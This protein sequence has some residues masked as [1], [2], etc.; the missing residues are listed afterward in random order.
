MERTENFSNQYPAKIR[1]AFVYLGYARMITLQTDSS[2]PVRELTPL[3]RSVETA[4]LRAVQQYLL[5][6]MDFAE[7]EPK[8]QPQKAEDGGASSTSVN[9]TKED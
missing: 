1:A 6:E 3:E 5:G 8:A 9:S 4:A 7:A 2:I